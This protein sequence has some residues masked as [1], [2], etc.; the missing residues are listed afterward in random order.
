MVQACNE[1]FGNVFI[2][3]E[4]TVVRQLLSCN[5]RVVLISDEVDGWG[6]HVQLTPAVARLQLC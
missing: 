3:Y 2:E 4:A 5:S 1:S 6:S